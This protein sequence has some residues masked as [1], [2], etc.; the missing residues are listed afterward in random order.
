[1]NCPVCANTMSKRV[2]PK[3]VQVDYCGDHGV[4]LDVGE[5]ET[6]LKSRQ[7]ADEGSGVGEI[8]TDVAKKVGNA[9]AFG[10][11][12]TLGRRVVDGMIDAIFG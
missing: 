8:A 12:A 3:S 4:W 11:G 5:L 1:M 6:L 7:S 2:V 9:A 10:A